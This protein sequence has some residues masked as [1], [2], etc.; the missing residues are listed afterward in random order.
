MA[1]GSF[2]SLSYFTNELAQGSC[3]EGFLLSGW[4][5]TLC[6]LRPN[7]FRNTQHSV[8]NGS[9]VS[10]EILAHLKAKELL[11]LSLSRSNYSLARSSARAALFE[12]ICGP[13]RWLHQIPTVDSSACQ[14]SRLK[15]VRLLGTLPWI[16][17]A[18]LLFLRLILCGRTF[19]FHATCSKLP[20]GLLLFVW[21][22]KNSK[23]Y[24]KSSR[25]FNKTLLKLY[26]FFV[27]RLVHTIK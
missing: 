2:S 21:S 1:K 4:H 24:N 23:K 7:C 17:M 10:F 8:L 9:A 27:L 15:L 12:W 20:E 16:G 11:Y 3:A 6:N 13:T 25:D 18:K 19:L 5:D 14:I 26:K 22:E